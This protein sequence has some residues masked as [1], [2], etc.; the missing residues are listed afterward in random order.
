MGASSIFCIS[1]VTYEGSL[2]GFEGQAPEI[3]DQPPSTA[4]TTAPS[5]QPPSAIR[6]YRLA[7]ASRQPAH[8][9]DQGQVKNPN[10]RR[11]ISTES[12]DEED[13]DMTIEDNSSSGSSLDPDEF[14]AKRLRT[15]T[16]VTRGSKTAIS[17]QPA[18]DHVLGVDTDA[19]V[20]AESVATSDI[21]E[22][23]TDP[24][25]RASSPS[26]PSP[27]GMDLDPTT[28]DIDVPSGTTFLHVQ[29]VTSVPSD[30][31]AKP[32]YRSP[33][34]HLDAQQKVPKFL[35]AKH[36]IY[37]YLVK[38]NEPGFK[39]LLDEYIAFELADRSGVRGNLSTTYRPNAV[40]WW[41][42]RARPDKL[43]PFDSLNSFSRSIV[44]WWTFIQPDW[45]RGIKCGQTS[46]DEGCWEHL[47]QPGTNGLLNVVI[48]VHWWARI[49]EERNEPVDATYRWLTEDI[50][51]V[52]SQLTQV[53][54]E[55]VSF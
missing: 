29:Q 22:T 16:I 36:N 52:F 55:G 43:P 4:N 21:G 8:V 47:Y 1:Y 28:P 30:A 13:V 41:S 40:T 23:A 44:Q 27:P 2:E 18:N 37:G 5:T 26:P 12:S 17:P 42:S 54:R 53:A 9:A 46:R 39:A 20:A 25:S 10:K 7:G 38:V 33:N 11:I 34:P 31:N 14:P 50:T 19:E 35:T 49:L 15:S 6:S 51:W 32:S 24:A 3:A 48:L 45:Q